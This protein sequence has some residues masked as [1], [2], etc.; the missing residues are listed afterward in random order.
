MFFCP[1]LCYLLS[2]FFFF[3]ALCAINMQM[4]RENNNKIFKVVTTNSNEN[5]VN[6]KINNDNWNKKLK[7]I[8][9]VFFCKNEQHKIILS[10]IKF[11]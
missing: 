5:A 11:I 7:E 6:Y 9:A 1:F 10:M 3:H 8:V 2:I 4:I